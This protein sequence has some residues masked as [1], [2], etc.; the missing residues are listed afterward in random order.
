MPHD[1]GMNITIACKQFGRSGG[2]ETFLLNFTRHL[3][4]RGHSVRVLTA[5]GDARMEGV[6]IGRLGLPLSVRALR[7]W[8]L[9]RR[10]RA[11]LAH[12][13]ADVT[14]SDQK[15]L[16]A[17]VVRP[18]GGVQRAYVRQRD[19][20]YPTALGRVANRIH[21]ALSLRERLRVRIDDELYAPPGPKCVIANS[22]M[23]RRNL[24]RYYPHLEDRIRVVYNGAD[25][26]RFSPA[27]RGEHRARVR[28]ETGVPDRALLCVFVGHDWRRKGLFPLIEALGILRRSAL[29]RDVYALVVGRGHEN[30]ARIYAARHGAADCLRF[31]G[32]VRPDACYGA[33]DIAVLPSF[34]D[35][36]ANVTI[37]ALACGLPVVTSIYN[38]AYEMLTPGENGF[39]ARDPADAAELAGMIEHWADPGRLAEGG[40]SARA[41]ALR[42]PLAGQM[43]KI[44]DALEQAA[45]R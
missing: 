25:L 30:A 35:P 12:E 34:F 45:A 41:T 23:V 39:A 31:A 6:E 9:A 43:E 10:S 21:R 33:A 37:E 4:A 36:C 3:L 11:A 20:S 17:D 28:R 24:V 2:A 44:V 16:G 42:Y 1:K 19:R 14:F 15:C 38:G 18:G 7:D 5:Q 27:L 32:D 22:D 8:R 40:V 29:E 13:R 26:E